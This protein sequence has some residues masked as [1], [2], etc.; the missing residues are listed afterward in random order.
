MRYL[1]DANWVIS[2]DVL[3]PDTEVARQYAGIRLHLRSQ[4]Q[5]LADNDRRIAATALAHD[6]TLVSRDTHF[7]RIP[8]LRLYSG[9]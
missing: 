3:A 2:V 9:E 1:L 6:L 8:W 7:Q 5:I 4:G